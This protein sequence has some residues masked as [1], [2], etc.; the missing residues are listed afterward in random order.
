CTLKLTEAAVEAW[1]SPLPFDAQIELQAYWTVKDSV[2]RTI[3]ER[4]PTITCDAP[5][6]HFPSGCA[7]LL[8]YDANGDGLIDKLEAT[9]ATD[10]YNAGIITKEEAV[11][12]VKVYFFEGG[13]INNKC[14]GCYVA[15]PAHDTA[16]SIAVTDEAG[17]PITESAVGE[18][19]YITG[20]L[21]DIV[22]NVALQGAS[23]TLYRN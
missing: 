20:Q 14:S 6:P 8:H 21:R 9:H 13:K 11:F 16:L 22:D 15:P 4:E 1:C 19:V 2:T 18:T 10:D 7:L 3:P 12:V 17:N 5:T 23:I